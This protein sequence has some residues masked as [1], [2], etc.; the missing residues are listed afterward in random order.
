MSL[1]SKGNEVLRKIPLTFQYP[2]AFLFKT[3]IHY[4]R[5]SIQAKEHSMIQ[6]LTVENIALITRADL[7]LQPGLTAIT[8]ETGAGKSLLIDSLLLALGGRAE[9]HLVRQGAPKAHIS[10]LV[11]LKTN[12]QAEHACHDLGIDL[13]D[14]QLLIQRELTAEGRSTVRINGRPTTVGILRS[15]S[16]HIADLHGQHDHRNLLNPEKQLEL[17]DTWIGEPAQNLKTELQIQLARVQALKSQIKTLQ[18]S[19]RDR[20]QRIDLLEF[21]ISEIIEA[22]LQ[23]NESDSLKTQ[24]NRLVHAQKLGDTFNLLIDSLSESENSAAERIS[25]ATRDLTHAITL[26]PTLS[27]TLELTE[28]AESALQEAIFQLR[29]YV[30]TLDYNPEQIEIAAARLDLISRLKKKYGESEEEI[31]NY[32]TNAQSELEQLFDQS[33]DASQLTEQLQ[34]Q[35]KELESVANSLSFIRHQKAKDF[36]KQTLIHIRELALE[37][38]EFSL[39]FQPKEIDEAGQEIVEFQFSANPGE[40]TQ[41]LHKIASGGELSRVMLAI[42]VAC[43]DSQGVQTLIFDEVDTGLSGRAA[44]ITARKLQQLSTHNQVIVISHL[45]QVA[46]A[47]DHHIEIEKTTSKNQTK[48]ELHTLKQEN[49]PQAIARLLGGE[50]I[51]TSALANAHEILQ[52]AQR[53]E[54]PLVLTG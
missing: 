39:Q 46:A 7:T 25:V 29:N 28:T 3:R 32:L 6:S 14:H 9:S 16:P 41:P 13:E 44:A 8:G 24:L 22:D 4:S 21:Q 11:D 27:P 17:L 15:L 10:L 1:L 45:A 26:D 42:K 5:H 36:A 2:L 47:A 43:A 51:G 49:R 52:S 35:T 40:P 34:T 50:E 23:P 12:P 20:A 37:K 48:T 31:L 18:T 53:P 30:E 19:E 54:N 38:A 33:Q